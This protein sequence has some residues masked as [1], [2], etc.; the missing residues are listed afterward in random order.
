MRRED[1]DEWREYWTSDE[2]A[3]VQEVLTPEELEGEVARMWVKSGHYRVAGE[4]GLDAGEAAVMR[5][6]S[7]MAIHD[8]AH[9][10]GEDAFGGA[11]PWT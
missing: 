1:R 6:R 7:M 9:E 10:T 11:P 5:V 4:F 2:Y 3:V 8:A